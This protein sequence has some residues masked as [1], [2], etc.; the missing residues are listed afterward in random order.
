[1]RSQPRRVEENKCFAIAHGALID[2]RYIEPGGRR[3]RCGERLAEGSPDTRHLLDDRRCCRSDFLKNFPLTGY[4]DFG[5]YQETDNAQ[6]AVPERRRSA[7]TVLRRDG[8]VR[9][10]AAAAQATGK[11]K[12]GTG[13]ALIQQ[14]DAIQT[15]KLVASTKVRLLNR[16]PT[17]DLAGRDCS[18]FG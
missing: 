13:V 12:L 2:D 16:L 17:L 8:P 10:L 11:I 7:G 3:D 6:D 14:R 18:F 5:V 4:F 9:G 15:A 1:M